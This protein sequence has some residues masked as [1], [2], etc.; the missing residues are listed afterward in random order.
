MSSFQEQ[1]LQIMDDKDHPLYWQL[2][3]GEGTKPMLKL[4]Y[5]QEWEVYVRD[6]PLYLAR[7]LA[8]NPPADVRQDLA[9][10]LYEEETGKLTI[11][12]PHPELFIY[13]MT[14]L[15]FESTDFEKVRLLPAAQQY[16][17]WLDAVTTS[18]DWLLAASVVTIFVE[19]SRQ[20]RQ[21]VEGQAKQESPFEEKV[22]NH[23]LVKHYGL[24]A[25]FLQ[26]QKAHS[27]A[28]SGHRIAAWR[29]VRGYAESFEEQEKIVRALQKS[30]ELWTAY[31]DAVQVQCLKTTT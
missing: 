11:G 3:G 26:L 29:M 13:M 7:I 17:D 12:K 31:R 10:N 4:H 28:E 25:K 18:G 2:M 15:G 16:R 8:M 30:L 6:F 5:Q 21:E 1:L 22:K 14:G 24:D 27:Q 20:D 9:E 23:P 19:G